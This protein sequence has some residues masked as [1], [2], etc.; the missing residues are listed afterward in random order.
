MSK[1]LNLT[2]QRF[3]RLAV[4]AEG[5]RGDGN[6]KK[7]LWHC[8][9]DCGNKITVM[10]DNLRCGHTKSCGCWS[11]E[12]SKQSKIKHGLAGSRIYSIWHAMRNRCLNPNNSAFKRYGGV[13]IGVC[14]RWLVLENFISD[15]GEPPEGY[16]IDRIDS[17]KGYSPENCRWAS[18]ATQ[19]RNSRGQF[20]KTSAYKGVHWFKPVKKWR[21]EIVV[22]GKRV[23]LGYFQDEHVAAEAYDTA[24]FKA[25]GSE[26]YLN[27]VSPVHIQWGCL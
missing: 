17:T 5:G 23:S 14:E 3:G 16:S 25:W 11:K 18:A 10:G 12:V 1:K 20:N 7:L 13:G 2:G 9:C 22:N 24:A 6:R 15:M 19:A 21:A 4:V 8:I 27:R 26:A